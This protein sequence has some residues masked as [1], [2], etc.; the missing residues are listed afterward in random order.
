MRFV[1]SKESVLRY[2]LS[3]ALNDF[4]ASLLIEALIK[5]NIKCEV[6]VSKTDESVTKNRGNICSSN[7]NSCI[8]SKPIGIKV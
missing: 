8:K 2:I 5:L 1:L 4:E 7:N 3:K 6:I